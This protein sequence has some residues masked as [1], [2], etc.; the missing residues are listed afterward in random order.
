[1]KRRLVRIFPDIIT[2]Y[3][4]ADRAASLVCFASAIRQHRM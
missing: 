3:R 2:A 1:M 4:D